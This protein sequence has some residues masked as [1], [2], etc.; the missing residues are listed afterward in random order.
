MGSVAFLGPPRFGKDYKWYI[1]GI[2]PANW[3][4]DGLPPTS[5]PPLLGEPETIIDLRLV[6]ISISLLK[7]MKLRVGHSF[8]GC[9]EGEEF[10]I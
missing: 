1:S 7:L 3:G 2:F 4:M 6:Q 9:D 10:P 8:V 5:H